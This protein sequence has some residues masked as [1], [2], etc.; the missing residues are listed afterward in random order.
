[1]T[2]CSYA[3][4]KEVITGSFNFTASAQDRNAENL[5]FISDNTLAKEY[6]EYW[7]KRERAST[8]YEEVG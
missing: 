5:V 6:T 8:P 3:Y 4:G 2:G 1:M 7:K